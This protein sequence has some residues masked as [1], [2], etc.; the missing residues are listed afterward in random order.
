[1][2]F[3]GT[4]LRVLCHIG[5]DFV[6]QLVCGTIGNPAKKKKLGLVS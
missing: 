5:K 1:M 6:L 3:K 2:A 4:A